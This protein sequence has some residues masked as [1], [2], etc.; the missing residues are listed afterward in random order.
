MGFD[1]TRGGCVSLTL[2]VRVRRCRQARRRRHRRRV[3]RKNLGCRWRSTSVRGGA[4][5]MYMVSTILRVCGNTLQEVL[6]LLN[7]LAQKIKTSYFQS[8]KAGYY[9]QRD[10]E[11]YF[12][13]KTDN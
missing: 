3:A 7:I 5:E 6:N 4:N 2:Y 1:Q 11:I 9:L 13:N 10:V 12:G 8:S